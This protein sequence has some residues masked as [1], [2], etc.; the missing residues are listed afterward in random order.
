MEYK[1]RYI[2]NRKKRKIKNRLDAGFVRVK[3]RG[4]KRWVRKPGS[5]AKKEKGV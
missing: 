4:R 1:I 3:V 2:R 5:E